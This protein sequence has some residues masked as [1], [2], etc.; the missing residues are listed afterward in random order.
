MYVYSGEYR[1]CEVGLETKFVD[2]NGEHLRTGDIVCLL[3]DGVWNSGLTVVVAD[4]WKSYSDGTHVIK[5]GDLEFFIMGIKDVV[6]GDSWNAVLV[7]RFEDV[8]EGEHWSDFGF[9]YKSS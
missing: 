7:K 8:I 6:L 2:W 5:E 9:N 3:H 4:Q 1:K